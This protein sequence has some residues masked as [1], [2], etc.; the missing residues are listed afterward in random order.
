MGQA[1]V[2][3]LGG[4]VKNMVDSRSGLKLPVGVQIVVAGLED[5]GRVAVQGMVACIVVALEDVHWLKVVFGELRMVEGN[6][7]VVVVAAV[8]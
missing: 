8:S 2:L 3:D 6:L 4:M 7:L 5:I 1:L